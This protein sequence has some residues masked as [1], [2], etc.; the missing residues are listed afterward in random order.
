MLSYHPAL[1]L[2]FHLITSPACGDMT[3]G[4]AS[5]FLLELSPGPPAFVH[6]DNLA[7]AGCKLS[8]TYLY[9]YKVS[10]VTFSPQLTG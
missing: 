10:R 9:S 7:A 8:I 5:C 2:L 4:L 1:T 6:N 3:P